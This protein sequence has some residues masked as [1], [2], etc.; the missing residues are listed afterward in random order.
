M[1]DENERWGVD[2]RL[3]GDLRRQNDLHP[4]HDL[5]AT[6]RLETGRVDLETLAAEDNLKQALLLR[7][8]SRVG[9]LAPLGHPEYGSRLHELI[10]ELNTPRNRN[11][12]KM[13]VLQ[14]LAQEPRVAEVLRVDVT[15]HGA[16]PGRIDIDVD[17][18]PIFSDRVL[19]LVF[20]FFIE[21][22]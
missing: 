14:A 8:L 6:E 4:G 17:L 12:A 9:E 21:G 13:Y 2:L 15:T 3:L 10:G 18:H 7:F 22:R 20:P 16:D 1:N 11:R 5:F 19:N